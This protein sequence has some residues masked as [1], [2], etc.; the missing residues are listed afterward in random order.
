MAGLAL[1]VSS[2][3]PN[4]PVRQESGVFA[5]HA[6]H[7]LHQEVGGPERLDALLPHAVGQLG[8]ALGRLDG[9]RLAGDAGLERVG[10]GEDAAEDVEIGGSRQP[11]QVEGVDL[12]GGAGEVRVDLETVHVADDHQRRVFQRLAVAVAVACRLP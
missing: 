10:I 6:E 8:E 3:L 9:H 12:L 5:E 1:P 11:G 7:E 4:R 2:S